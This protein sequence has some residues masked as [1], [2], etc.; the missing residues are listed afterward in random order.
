MWHFQ[1]LT[2][3]EPLYLEIFK[4]NNANSLHLIQDN[5]KVTNFA[6]NN[7]WNSCWIQKYD[8]AKW[9]LWSRF[10]IMGIL[11]F[12]KSTQTW[13]PPSPLYFK[14]YMIRTHQNSIKNSKILFLRPFHQAPWVHKPANPRHGFIQWTKASSINLMSCWVPLATPCI[15]AVPETHLLV[16]NN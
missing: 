7:P 10:K 6:Q 16:Q 13:P 4:L 11:D 3:F 15:I 12:C 9:R 1:H 14:Y 5:F 8:Q 2:H